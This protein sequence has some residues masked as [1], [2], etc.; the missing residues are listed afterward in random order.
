MVK[1]NFQK[2]SF[3]G[4]LLHERARGQ[5]VEGKGKSKE[6]QSNSNIYVTVLLK[7]QGAYTSITF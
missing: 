2:F 7:V 1:V 5:P 3:Q 6:K 4:R